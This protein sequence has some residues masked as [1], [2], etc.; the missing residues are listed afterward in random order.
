MKKRKT[1]MVI[2]SVLV[3]LVGSAFV[4]NGTQHADATPHQADQVAPT[5]DNGAPTPNQGRPVT[6]TQLHEEAARKLASMNKKMNDPF[7]GKMLLLTHETSTDIKKSAHMD[8]TPYSG[9]YQKD[10]A[11]VPN[12]Q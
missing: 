7:R 4:I 2:V 9:W 12:G 6:S 8:T 1:P 11:A 5:E 10:S 3:V